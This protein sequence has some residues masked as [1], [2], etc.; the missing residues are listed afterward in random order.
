MRPC[1]CRFTTQRYRYAAPI[2][3]PPAAS[4]ASRSDVSLPSS[5][6]RQP[7][8]RPASAAATP[9][10]KGC[11]MPL[12]STSTLTASQRLQ[13][14]IEAEVG[15]E[16]KSQRRRSA[17]ASAP[18]GVTPLAAPLID[19]ELWIKTAD[20]STLGPLPI[21]T[22]PWA[23]QIRAY[24]WAL[25][26]KAAYLD[27]GMGAGKS[28][29]TV[30]LAAGRKHERVL[31]LCPKSVVSGWPNQFRRH[32]THDFLTVALDSGSVL[33]RVG[34]ATEALNLARVLDKQAVVIVN[35]EAIVSPAMQ[36]F[37]RAAKF[38]LLVCDEAH[39]LKSQ[40]GLISKT[41]YQLF[42][43][44]DIHR[45]FLSGTPLPHSP[46]DAF[47]QFRTLRDDVLGTTW[48][49]F[50][51]RYSVPDPVYPQT[52]SR[53][54][55][56]PWLNEDE[57]AAKLSPLMY[58]VGR[59]VLDLPPAHHVV[60]EV[61]LGKKARELYRTLEEGFYAEVESGEITA[62]NALTRLIRLRQITSGFTR[63]D[64]GDLVEVDT[65]KRDMLAET[66]DELPPR[67]PVVVFADF[68][69]DLAVIKAVAE[70][71]GRRYG[72]VSGRANCLIESKF[73]PDVD[74]LGVQIK[75]GGAGVDL[76][77]A[78]YGIYYSLGYSLGE[79][80]QSEARLDRPQADGSKRTDPVIFTHIVAV[81]TV[82]SSIYAALDERRSVVDAVIRRMQH[83]SNP[84]QLP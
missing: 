71:Q 42:K 38:D 77:R 12:S 14:L 74:V 20:P 83:P 34:A 53:F 9:H 60:R 76:A 61:K 2:S 43:G 65:A 46:L 39:K 48:T 40:G 1:F 16:T 21:A 36:A 64:S 66:L 51:L 37:I 8:W 18:R 4:V 10:Y 75:A 52:T 81:G 33:R 50:R 56:N 3:P 31:I 24:H 44:R 13:A 59:E 47:G 23:H 28:A 26:K 27:F 35:Y 72:E 17:E 54:A 78:A 32:G 22:T 70:S 49:R 82:E 6:S 30:A 68:T 84:P 57:L 63:L 15:P 45:L 67:E 29:I 41:V 79:K 80:D 58:H 19:H 62:A 11:S 69:H 5:T 73:P 7:M 25:P 55:E